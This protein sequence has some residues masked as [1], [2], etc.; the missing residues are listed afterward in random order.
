[1]KVSD[2]ASAMESIAPSR[3]AAAWDNVGLLVGDPAAPLARVLLTVDCTREIIAEAVAGGQGTTIVSYHPVLFDAQKRFVAGSAAFEAAR[4]GVAVYCPHTALDVALG[5]TNDVLADAVGMRDREPLRG[6]DGTDEACKLVTFV[7]EAHVEA[8]SRAVFA[9]GA[10]RIGQYT[11]CSFRST[12]TG[13]FFGEAG[14]NPV[15]GQAGRLEL[16]PE[17]RLE[18]ITPMGSAEAVVKALRAVHPYE[19]PAFDLVRLAAPPSGLGFGRVGSVESAPA[20][21]HVERLKRSLGLEHVLVGGSLD[22]EVSRA[23]VCAGSGGDLLGEAV[24][25]GAQLVVTGEL[26]HHD[27]L[28]AVA[29]GLVVVCV[30]HSTSERGALGPLARRLSELLPG[31]VVTASALDRDPFAFA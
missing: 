13:T 14:T 9:A 3:W 8:V 11:S 6:V 16:A 30:R 23:A 18:V 21:V 20:R 19:E 12:G 27:A 7:P 15:V 28:R 4:A 1:M 25:S 26:R 10:G 5:G 29:R 17:V 31:V 22:C 2:L 24:C